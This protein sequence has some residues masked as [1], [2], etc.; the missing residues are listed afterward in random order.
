MRSIWWRGS[1]GKGKREEE[2]RYRAVA[3]PG[4]DNLSKPAER[5][6]LDEFNGAEGH[7]CEWIRGR[8]REEEVGVVGGLVSCVSA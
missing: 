2:G 1:D 3:D 4:M 5:A 8:R 7:I 6:Q